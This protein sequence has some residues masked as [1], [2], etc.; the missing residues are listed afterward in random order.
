[1]PARAARVQITSQAKRVTQAKGSMSE[2]AIQAL[3]KTDSAGDGKRLAFECPA[4]QEYCNKWD[5]L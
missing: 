3:C 5:H 1:M 2:Q 4:M